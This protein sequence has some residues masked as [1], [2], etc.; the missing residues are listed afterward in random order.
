MRTDVAPDRQT[1]HDLVERLRP[2]QLTAAISLL[3]FMLL[4]PVSR[5]LASAPIDD[6]PETEY[7]RSA[8]READEWFAQHE[9][10]IAHDEVKRQLGI[11]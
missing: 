3:Q 1:A 11:E 7:E 8:V 5:A 10:G 2:E 6:E 4:D 9:A